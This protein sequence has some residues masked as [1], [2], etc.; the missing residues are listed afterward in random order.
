MALLPANVAKFGEG[1]SLPEND[2]RL[3]LAVREAAHARLFVQ[4][5]WLRGHLL[6]AI[7]AYARGIHIDTSKIEELARETR[8]EQPRGHPGGALAGCL[9][10]AAH[11]RPGAG[12]RKAGDRP[13]PGGGLGGRTELGCHRE[14]AALGRGAARD[15]PAPPGHRRA[16]GARVLLPR[17]TRTAAAPAPRGRRAVGLAQGRARGGRPRRRFGS[18][19]ICCPPPRTWKT[20]RASA[21]AANSPRPATPRWTTPCRSCSAAD[22]TS[23]RAPRPRTPRAPDTG[24][25][26]GVRATDGVQRARHEPA[27]DDDRPASD[28]GPSGRR[29]HAQ[30]LAE[31]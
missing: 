13:R 18:T 6:G 29:R 21:N 16:G 15:R 19:P 26:R 23:R 24:G 8:S 22:S 3:F 11:S 28:G 9:H 25:T 27:A 20:R 10:A 14:A 7:E 2:I 5:P 30:G 17:G 4:V 1:L 12:P 31:R